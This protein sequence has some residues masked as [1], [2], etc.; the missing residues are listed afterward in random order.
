MTIN[1]KRRYLPWRDAA[2]REGDLL[3]FRPTRL[4]RIIAFAGRSLW[5]HAGKL[6]FVDSVPVC[7]ECREFFGLRAVALCHLV[8][9]FPGRIDV[10][11]HGEV[12]G[13]DDRIARGMF[14]ANLGKP[15]AWRALL[16]VALAHTPILWR[17]YRPKFTDANGND[18]PMFCSMA[19]SR[20][21]RK[22]GHDPVPNL[23]DSYTEPA[24]LAR[25]D[26]YG[27]HYACTLTEPVA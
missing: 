7:F 12:E 4:T 21:D 10:F 8:K 11:H 14:I 26:F 16:K 6:F 1:F 17:W 23:A 27:R 9:E 2:L 3:L 25:S 20:A 5:S 22:A 13:Y 18:E 19:V 15:Y 24:D